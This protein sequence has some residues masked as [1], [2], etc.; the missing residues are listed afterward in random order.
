MKHLPKFTISDTTQM[1]SNYS[2]K[3]ALSKSLARIEAGIQ[4]HPKLNSDKTRKP[5]KPQLMPL[6]FLTHVRAW[7]PQ[8]M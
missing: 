5:I 8:V 1:L 6:Q 2:H 3:E 7:L 4:E